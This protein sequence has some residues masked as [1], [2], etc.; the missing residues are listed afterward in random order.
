[1]VTVT[2]DH[3]HRVAKKNRAISVICGKLLINSNIHHKI[4][5]L[6]HHPY[7]KFANFT[8]IDLAKLAKFNI[9]A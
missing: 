7:A 2:V 1:M 3:R 5:S 6:S 8:D 4:P 9:K